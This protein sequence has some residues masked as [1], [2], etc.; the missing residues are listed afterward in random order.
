MKALHNMVNLLNL[1]AEWA[2]QGLLRAAISIALLATL[3][4][5]QFG[6]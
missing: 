2:L 4:S 5:G 3:L 6:L 1:M